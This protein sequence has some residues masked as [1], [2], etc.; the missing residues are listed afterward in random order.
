MTIYTV[1]FG[2]ERLD[3]IAKAL[4][5]TEKNGAVDALLT[6]NPG[7]AALAVSGVVPEGTIIQAPAV[8]DATPSAVFTLAWE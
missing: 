4:L 8:F 6:A 7:L 2:G 1:G 3:K 5:Q